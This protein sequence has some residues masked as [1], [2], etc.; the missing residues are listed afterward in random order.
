MGTLTAVAPWHAEY[1]A[2]YRQHW[3]RVVR[4]CRLL[5][6]DSQEAQEVAQEVFLRLAQRF[7]GP[8]STT[9]WAAWLT[10]V[11]PNACQDRRR[12]GWWRRWRAGP[13]ANEEIDLVDGEPT[14]E[15]A[16][17]QGGGRGRIWRAFPRLSPRQ[18]EVFG[19]RIIE[20]G[21]TEGAAG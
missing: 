8:D 2:L 11:S 5:L 18:R 13:R 9:E 7:Q 20:G 17:L 10:R 19:L 4:L 6:D 21:A 1:E 15:R 16:A 12:S 3:A 14:P